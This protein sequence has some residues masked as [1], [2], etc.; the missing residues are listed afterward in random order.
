VPP[1]S[2]TTLVT[3]YAYKT[4]PV[5]CS[6]PPIRGAWWS[7]DQL[8]CGWGRVTQTIDDYTNGVPTASSNS[9]TN[10]T[11][12]GLG[13]ELTVQA[14]MPSGTPS[15]TTQYVYGVT[16]GRRQCNHLQ[17]P[18]GQGRVPDPTTGKPE[19]LGQQPGCVCIQQFWVIY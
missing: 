1:S 17:R 13:D 11:Y 7:A 12:D 15:Q 5:G 14:V 2:D 8:R 18:L 16:H 3:S 19:H 6:R 10:Y 4:P 9:T